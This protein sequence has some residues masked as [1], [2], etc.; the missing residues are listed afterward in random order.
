VSRP[1]RT[2]LPMLPAG[3]A[4]ANQQTHIEYFDGDF[5]PCDCARPQKGCAM[6]LYPTQPIT[7]RLVRINVEPYIDI[8]CYARVCEVCLTAWI[9]EPHLASSMASDDPR[10]KVIARWWNDQRTAG[11]RSYREHFGT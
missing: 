1:T 11:R 7:Q 2:T 6:P 9:T 5:A 3:C 8:W 10:R 4:N